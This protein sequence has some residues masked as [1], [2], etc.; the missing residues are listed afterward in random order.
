LR[1]SSGSSQRREN[2]HP[3]RLDFLGYDWLLIHNGSARQYERLVPENER[4]LLESDN[5]SARVFEFLRHKIID[6]YLSRPQRSL[7]EA[8]RSAYALEH[9]GVCEAAR[10][11][12]VGLRQMHPHRLGSAPARC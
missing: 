10:R 8:C 9:G 11:Q 7:I 5:D 1:R 6:R 2:N 3:F 12:P 4:L